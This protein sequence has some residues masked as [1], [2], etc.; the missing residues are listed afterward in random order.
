M[1]V[2]GGLEDDDAESADT[3]VVN[4]EE[5][6]NTNILDFEGLAED[7]DGSDVA[8]D[9]LRFT[10]AVMTSPVSKI[11]SSLQPRMQKPTR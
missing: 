6:M 4:L 8:K 9:M 3:F 10:G 2:S 7:D 11:Y 5:L 1:N